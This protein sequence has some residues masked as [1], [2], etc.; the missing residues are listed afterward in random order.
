[1]YPK[2]MT[3]LRKSV[4]PER[5]L[6]LSAVNIYYFITYIKLGLFHFYGSY[7]ECQPLEIGNNVHIKPKVFTPPEQ[8]TFKLVKFI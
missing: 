2:N 1:M 8:Q 4:Y 6:S 5:T 7:K 3:Y